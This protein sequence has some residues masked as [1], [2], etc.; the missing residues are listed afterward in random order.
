MP[1]APA[2]I[3]KVNNPPSA[4]NFNLFNNSASGVLDSL[5]ISVGPPKK[6][7]NVPASSTSPTK[8]ASAAPPANAP[9]PYLFNFSFLL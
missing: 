6:S 4:P 2:P 1:L 9:L 8:A 5:S 7:P 3:P